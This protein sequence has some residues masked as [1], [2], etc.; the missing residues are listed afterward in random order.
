M[1]ADGGSRTA[2]LE[3]QAP[4]G[5]TTADAEAAGPAGAQPMDLVSAYRPCLGQAEAERLERRADALDVA[6]CEGA[7]RA[8]IDRVALPGRQDEVGRGGWGNGA[9][10]RGR[11]G[12]VGARG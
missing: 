3:A 5:S 1:L 7:R 2:P 9:G 8:A 4:G 6:V 12:W 10:G 11:G